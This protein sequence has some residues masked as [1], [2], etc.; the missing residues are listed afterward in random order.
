MKKDVVKQIK[1]KEKKMQ[2]DDNNDDNNKNNISDSNDKVAC[3]DVKYKV[4]DNRIDFK[5]LLANTCSFDLVRAYLPED[6]S[7]CGDPSFIEQ[8]PFP[9]FFKKDDVK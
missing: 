7:K 8:Y 9:S 6:K 3:F 4:L 5:T 2:L 1:I